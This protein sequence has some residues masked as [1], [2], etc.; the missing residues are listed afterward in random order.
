MRTV[1]SRSRISP[2]SWLP[3]NVW[4]RGAA[5]NRMHGKAAPTGKS[6][7]NFWKNSRPSCV[8]VSACSMM[9][10]V[11]RSSADPVSALIMPAVSSSGLKTDSPQS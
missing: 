2:S 5:T 1:S 4:K 7:G 11:W 10:I 3:S 8:S 6:H 9:S